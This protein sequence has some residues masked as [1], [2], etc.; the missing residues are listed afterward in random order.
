MMKCLSELSHTPFTIPYK[1][2]SNNNVIEKHWSK[3]YLNSAFMDIA[4]TYNGAENRV[5]ITS[6]RSTDT[7]I[8]NNLKRY[9]SEI[10]TTSI[11]L[12]L[13]NEFILIYTNK[14]LQ[15]MNMQI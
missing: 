10:V 11:D 5:Y 9:I 4:R 1:P 15:C 12:L 13:N 6:E 3:I 2:E 8:D 14:I 7:I